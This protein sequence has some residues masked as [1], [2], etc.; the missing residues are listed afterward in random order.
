MRMKGK[1]RGRG[2]GKWRK[3]E[4]EI[5]LWL[6]G[7]RCFF[8]GESEGIRV[9]PFAFFSQIDGWLGLS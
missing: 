1:E 4:E 6:S 5:I 3:R 8:R 2:R 9:I 7:S